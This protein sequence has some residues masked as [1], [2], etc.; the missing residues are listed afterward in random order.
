M[1]EANNY[2]SYMHQFIELCQG[3]ILLKWVA[4]ERTPSALECGEITASRSLCPEG[5][6]TSQEPRPSS[7][8][9][10]NLTALLMRQLSL[11]NWHQEGQHRPEWIKDLHGSMVWSRLW[12][13]SLH[14]QV[15]VCTILHTCKYEGSS[16]LAGAE[17]SSASG[18]WDSALGWHPLARKQRK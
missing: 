10:Q 3:E 12:S 9:A 6:E 1:K 7:G 2:K 18:H 5:P 14:R 16:S 11:S 15:G 8:L 17:M 4:P 13:S